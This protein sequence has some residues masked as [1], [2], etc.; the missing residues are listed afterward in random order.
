MDERKKWE[1]KFPRFLLANL[2]DVSRHI[3]VLDP[4]LSLSLVQSFAALQDE[5]HTVPPN[6]RGLYFGNEV[7]FGK[8]FVR[9]PFVVD[10]EDC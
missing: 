9:R 2:E 4:D 3:L 10:P 5:R 7:S 6:G 1:L 8:T